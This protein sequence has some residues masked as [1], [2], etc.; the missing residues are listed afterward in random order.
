LP[1][2]RC[3]R[4]STTSSTSCTPVRILP[5]SKRTRSRLALSRLKAR[6]R[7]Q[8]SIRLLLVPFHVFTLFRLTNIFDRYQLGCC[9]CVLKH[10]ILRC[11]FRCARPP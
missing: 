6:V 7:R 9:S 2:L 5:R 1:S 3:F 10:G 8:R 11:L 4:A